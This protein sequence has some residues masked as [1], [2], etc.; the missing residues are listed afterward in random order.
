[1]KK[2]IT[3]ILKW[4]Q[5]S[6]FA[7]YLS[8]FLITLVFFLGVFYL[9]DKTSQNTV[10]VTY[11]KIID[12]TIPIF[13]IPLRYFT[14]DSIALGSINTTRNP[15]DK[16]T[17]EYAVVG[18]DNTHQSFLLST[19]DFSNEIKQ[20]PPI[21]KLGADYYDVWKEWYIEQI[22]KYGN[23]AD[24]F[25]ADG[26]TITWVKEFDV[27]SDGKVEKIVGLCSIGG[28]HC[29]HEI[30]VVKDNKQIFS[31]SAGLTGRDILKTETG[32]GFYVHWVPTDGKWDRGLCCT[33]GYQKTR[34]VYK[35]GIFMP[36]YEQEV[37]YP[38][39]VI[40]H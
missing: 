18:G 9:A 17:L 24:R 39:V 1:M 6:I 27:D 5:V 23:L 29:P 3:N 7:E 2:N 36:V 33:L 14:Y 37:L 28:N 30:I 40:G 8:M 13:N 26:Y 12:P 20:L 25:W 34:F 19:D 10:G 4:F 38:K 22:K 11:N 35:D 16:N 32:N 21:K 31:T 15:D